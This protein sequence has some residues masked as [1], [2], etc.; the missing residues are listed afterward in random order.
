MPG[1][2]AVHAIMPDLPSFPPAGQRLRLARPCGSADALLLSRLAG[3]AR[4]LILTE[5]A[6]DALRLKEEIAWFAPERA[7]SLFPDWETLPYD[8]IS[9]HPDLISERLAALWLASQARIDV[10]VA[11]LAT[12]MQRLG[13]PA[14]LA[15]HAFLF[16]QGDRLDAEA[17]RKRLTEAGY[18]HVNQV[19]SPGEFAV[20]GGLLDLFP[21]GTALPFRLDL[22]DDEIES[23]RTFDPDTQRTLYKVNDIRLL[24]AREFP[25]DEAGITR[26]RQNYRE[27]FEGDPSKSKLYKDV[28]N[29]L[30]PGGIEYYL[31]LFFDD[32]ATL[33]DYLP[34]DT[35][36]V[37]HGDA[38]AAVEGCWKDTQNRHR[39]LVGDKDRPLLAADA[40]FLPPDV[41]FGRIRPYARIELQAPS[42]GDD[43][44]AEKSPPAPLSQMGEN[45]GF[46]PAPQV[47]T[48]R[49]A[50]D[51]Y[52]R[53]KLHLNGFNGATLLIAE[54]LGRR[55][56]IEGW[57][58]DLSELKIGDPV[59]HEATASAATSAWCTWISATATPNSCTSNTPT[60]PSSTCRWRSCRSS[61]AT[62]APTRNR[63]SCTRW[64]PA[65]GK[66][67]RRRPPSRCTTPPPNCCTSTPSAP[68]AR[69]T[70][71]SFKQH[72]LEAFADGFGFEETPDQQA[73]INA[74]IADMK[75]GKP[76]DR[77]V[78]GDVGFGKTEVAM[79][80]A[81]VAVADGKQ[82]AMLCPTT[83]LAEQHYQNFSDRFADW[84]VKIAE[85]SRFKSAKGTGP[86]SRCW[87]RARST[88]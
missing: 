85:M 82:V 13:P 64:A 26:F 35:A 86:P 83:L 52:A 36:L 73:A 22:F 30:A 80:A 17:F 39:M 47:D 34:A 42:V 65:S 18:S 33:F 41:F 1:F 88:S 60:A 69:A 55:E 4:L 72:D 78:C 40:L 84:P 62:A 54:S 8:P 53:L 5:S 77:L 20:R 51:P 44:D 24:P 58:R 32:T 15:A 61:R 25:L 48:D 27:R 3:K 29:K 2:A 74:V 59:V 21:M 11:P 63:S 12:A 56:T 19:L 68:R 9:P 81:F 71:S 10:L 28:S 45:T 37:L 79:R 6:Q 75:S 16:K 43:A 49:R 67:P 38:Q 46:A 87:A 31:P 66:R 7:I 23:I 50:E 14:F 57:L 70:R 76:M